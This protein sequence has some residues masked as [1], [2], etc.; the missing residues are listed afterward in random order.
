MLYRWV[1]TAREPPCDPS[2]P[3]EPASRYCVFDCGLVTKVWV[4]RDHQAEHEAALGRMAK[5]WL[6]AYNYDLE[7]AKACRDA[8]YPVYAGGAWAFI[9]DALEAEAAN[10]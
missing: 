8:E 10:D 5:E 6:T 7:T 3:G 1:A 9:V 2:A 4:V